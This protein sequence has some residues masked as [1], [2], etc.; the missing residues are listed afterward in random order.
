[1]KRIIKLLVSAIYGVFRRRGRSGTCVV[2]Y[3]HAVP[4]TQR[5][6]FARQMDVLLRLAKPVP[7]DVSQLESGRLH[8]AVTFDDAFR[9][10]AAN[11]I[12][13][14]LKR[15]IPVTVFI[16]TGFLGRHPDW[17]AEPDHPLRGETVMTADE[18][19]QLSHPLI[20]WGSHGVTHPNFTRLSNEEAERELRES[21]S[22][23]NATLFSFPFGAFDSRSVELARRGGYQRVFTTLPQTFR[24]AVDVF[25]VGRVSVE[26]TDWP[27]EFRLKVLGAY[28]WLPAAFAL[29]RAL[30]GNRSG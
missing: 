17:I 10:A 11:A 29:K 23:L 4:D 14:A 20:T 2:L 25:V 5:G 21:K 27:I 22:A 16:P 19:K 15:G 8:V 7:A 28:S 24:G 6:A 9:S 13:E 30:Q 18:I 3:Y 12:P 26:P 1:M